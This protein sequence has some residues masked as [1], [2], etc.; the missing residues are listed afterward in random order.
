VF[1]AIRAWVPDITPDVGRWIR[2]GNE[3]A[4][5]EYALIIWWGIGVM[6]LAIMIAVAAGSAAA[7]WLPVHPSSMSSWWTL[8]DRWPAGS[9]VTVDCV[10]DDGS[11]VQ[12]VL[13]SYNDSADDI[14]DRDL[15]LRPPIVYGPPGTTDQYP[16]STSGVSISARR[17]VMMSVTYTKPSEITANRG[18]IRK[19]LRERRRSKATSPPS[20]AET[21]GEE[22][23]NLG[24]EAAES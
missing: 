17:I 6:V 23:P 20:S 22:A 3:Y 4:K 18:G 5:Q 15:I 11:W 1:A 21:P 2:D 14:A 9:D 8:F 12:G 19:W 10:I 7:R 13:A 24:L 16:H